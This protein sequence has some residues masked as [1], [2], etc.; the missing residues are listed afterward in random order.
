MERSLSPCVKSQQQP[1]LRVSFAVGLGQLLGLLSMRQRTMNHG[2]NAPPT[3]EKG[4]CSV[5]PSCSKIRVQSYHE[6]RQATDKQINHHICDA[7]YITVKKNEPD[8]HRTNHLRRTGEKRAFKPPR[9]VLTLPVLQWIQQI[10]PTKSR[11]VRFK[12]SSAVTR[13]INPTICISVFG[14]TVSTKQGIFRSRQVLQTPSVCTLHRLQYAHTCMCVCV[15][16]S[17]SSH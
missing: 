8:N 1:T 15:C 11:Q 17:V 12:E 7:R 9:R 3:G 2:L 6:H 16:V 5:G 4:H 10:M 13:R 14:R